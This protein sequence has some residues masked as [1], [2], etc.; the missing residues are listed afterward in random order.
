MAKLQVYRASV[1]AAI[2]QIA[3]N[4][5]ALISAGVAFFAMLS[6]FPGLAALIAILGLVSDPVVVVV[7]LEQVR[8]L[9]PDQVYDIL[10][11]Q[12]VE[13]VSTSSDTLGW[14]G[15]LSL[16]VAL[17]SARAGVA[18]LMQGLN[19][20]YGT[21][22]RATWRHYAR[23]LLLTVS[24][25][26]VSIVAGLSVVVAPV[27]LAFL[28]L[29]GLA[30]FV[31]ELLRWIVAISV[32]FVGIGLLFRFGPNRRPERTQFLTAGALFAGIS[33]A[34]VSVGFSYYVSHFGNYNEVYGSIGAVIAM[35]I[36]LWITSFLVLLGAALNAELEARLPELRKSRN[37]DPQTYDVGRD[38]KNLEPT[39]DQ[40][41]LE[42]ATDP[43]AAGRE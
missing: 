5:L 36:W 43:Q 26:G 27:V 14:A 25:V 41:L 20:V 30:A 21:E 13:L 9:M 28:P 10:N 39:P 8:G 33:W 38:V 7:Q 32:M 18:A 11:D 3:R 17:W 40:N 15:L 2:G 1:V 16:L 29:G 42:V 19:A 24:L 4:N 6:V 37:T 34:G 35:L 31:A 12:I 23:A 22:A